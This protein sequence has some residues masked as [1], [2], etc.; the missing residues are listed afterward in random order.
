MGKQA[1]SGSFKMPTEIF[2][3][4]KKYMEKYTKKF[5]NVIDD[6]SDFLKISDNSKKQAKNLVALINESNLYLPCSISNDVSIKIDIKKSKIIHAFRA[7][8]YNF[9]E[10]LNP[11]ISKII[12]EKRKH[13]IKKAFLDL[14]L[15]NE[16]NDEIINYTFDKNLNIKYRWPVQWGLSLGEHGVVSKF[17]F[18][19]INEKLFGVSN[20]ITK[21][22][23]E[24]LNTVMSKLYPDIKIDF[25]KNRQLEFFSVDVNK[26]Q[27]GVKIYLAYKNDKDLISDLREFNYKKESLDKFK[28]FI[29]KNSAYYKNKKLICLQVLN[30]NITAKKAEIHI[31]DE[32]RGGNKNISILKKFI[33]FYSEDKRI[34]YNY[35]NNNAHALAVGE[36]F[37]TIYYIID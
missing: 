29:Q 20:E 26:D 1:R 22:K 18:G 31:K 27:I 12:L 19:M 23:F 11:K 17:C 13:M 9:F 34:N 16:K 28:K 24:M 35:S 14:D 4:P 5:I 36:K 25:L 10:N 21:K 3:V 32:Y 33:A 8:N 30:G 7:T 2:K 6:Y 15:L 37:I